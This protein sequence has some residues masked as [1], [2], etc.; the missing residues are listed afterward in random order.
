MKKIYKLIIAL[1]IP[2]L[3]GGLGSLFTA[4]SVKGWYTTIQKAPLNPPG[5]IFGPVWTTLFLMMGYALYIVWISEDKAKKTL[6]YV[7]FTIQ[8][9]L[10]VFWSV[11]FFGLKNPGLA[12]AEILILWLAI[13]FNIFI[14]YR[15][16][17]T[18][19]WLLVP[20]LLWVTFAAY[21]NYSIWI[22][23]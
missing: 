15:I 6:A 5:W 2:Q 20:Y 12:F 8:L 17:R 19:A 11:V 7:A 4:S 1:L 13:I 10:N 22:L 21:L 14:F 3:A 18:S 16:S 23:N 9:T